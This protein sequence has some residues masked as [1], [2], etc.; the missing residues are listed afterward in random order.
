MLRKQVL[1]LLALVPA[2]AGEGSTP[3]PDGGTGPTPDGTLP[4]PTQQA[5]VELRLQPPLFSG[6]TPSLS[7]RGGF[8]TAADPRCQRT[9]V[10]GCEVA[11]CPQ[12][13]I[14]NTYADPGKLAFAPSGGVV[15]FTPGASFFFFDADFVPWA[16][17]DPIT[18]S[19][20][21]KD[22]PA[23]EA[24][25]ASPRTLDAGEGRAV[26]GPPIV[27]SQPFK[28]TWVPIAED[29]LVELSQSRDTANGPF[30]ILV[31]CEVNGGSGSGTVPA[32][33]LGSFLRTASGGLSVQV[34]AHAMRE[35][36]VVA[37][38]FAVTYRVLR[39]FD[40]HFFHDV[41]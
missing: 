32:A 4:E 22:V 23:F 10:G 14:G 8:I 38:D 31:R 27:T 21:G 12:A 40:E 29:V 35:T 24:T 37:G 17:T 39:S 36:R 26:N 34:T 3:G 5:L 16:A 33:A 41:Q 19:A 15:Q 6:E 18:L 20:A 30:E 13:L 11:N 1:V 2:C 25:V 7:V 28:A 9:Q